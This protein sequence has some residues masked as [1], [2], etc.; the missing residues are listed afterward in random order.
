LL[1]IDH[2]KE[3]L[4]Q[5]PT[6]RGNE[7]LSSQ[8]KQQH[9]RHIPTDLEFIF[10]VRTGPGEQLSRQ[11]REPPIRPGQG[12]PHL[13]ARQAEAAEVR[14]TAQVRR[15]LDER[16]DG[17]VGRQSGARVSCD[18]S[19]IHGHGDRHSNDPEAVCWFMN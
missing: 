19:D 9:L 17:K 11:Q 1:P 10:L 4:Q 8:I 12:R 18:L 5:K 14:H 15:A 2:H 7:S 13:H 6:G 3:G 16:G